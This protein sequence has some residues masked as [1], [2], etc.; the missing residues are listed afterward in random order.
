MVREVSQAADN[1]NG[2]ETINGNRVPI[3]TKRDMQAQIAVKSR[4]TIALGGLVLSNKEKTRAK[5]PF[6]D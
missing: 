5:I 1:V 4:S 3:I 6:N 2:F